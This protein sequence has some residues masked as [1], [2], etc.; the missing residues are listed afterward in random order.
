MTGAGVEGLLCKIILILDGK[1][2]RAYLSI[3]GFRASL[4]TPPRVNIMGCELLAL[5]T[6]LL[7]NTGAAR[8]NKDLLAGQ[9]GRWWHDPGEG[10]TPAIIPNAY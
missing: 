2:Y 4:M 7:P 8:M 1:F 5:L 6:Y 10:E 9:A 3:S